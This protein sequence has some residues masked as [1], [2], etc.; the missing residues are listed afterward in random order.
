LDRVRRNG[1]GVSRWLRNEDAAGALRCSP[2]ASVSRGARCRRWTRC[3]VPASS[4]YATELKKDR[5]KKQM[6]I[7]HETW[8][9]CAPKPG[10]THV[11]FDRKN[12]V[13]VSTLAQGTWP[14]KIVHAAIPSREPHRRRNCQ[15]RMHPQQRRLA[16]ESRQRPE[17][18]GL[19]AFAGVT[20]RQL[21]LERQPE[22]WLEAEERRAVVGQ[23]RR[24]EQAAAAAVEQPG[25]R[26]TAAAHAKLQA[27]ETARDLHPH[28]R[29]LRQAAASDAAPEPST[30]P[31]RQ[32]PERLPPEH[33]LEVQP[34]GR[35]PNVLPRAD[36]RV[37]AL[38]LPPQRPVRRRRRPPAP[39]LAP[40]SALASAPA[41]VER[42]SGA[43]CSAARADCTPRA[44]CSSTTSA[45][46]PPARTH[47][48]ALSW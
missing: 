37:P 40:A 9:R 27:R 5:M 29:G 25:G 16:P 48:R 36:R 38:E 41:A 22:R 35:P 33:Q 13:G 42:G 47:H 34:A 7:L 2:V 11:M 31:K 3:R 43:P 18:V 14:P 6:F 44:R 20:E 12:A 46:R 30:D 4:S 39:P 15:L 26:P 24:Q 19:V 23:E 1:A 17:A 10:R 8:R 21:P 28:Q 32:P 45:P